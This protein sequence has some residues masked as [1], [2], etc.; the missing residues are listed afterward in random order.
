MCFLLRN[1]CELPVSLRKLTLMLKPTFAETGTNQRQRQEEAYK[2]FISYMRA[3]AGKYNF[4]I[5]IRY[6]GCVC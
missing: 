6:L 5:T 4:Y 3:V 2:V 1:T